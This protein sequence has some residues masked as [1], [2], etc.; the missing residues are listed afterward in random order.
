[1]DKMTVD[2]RVVECCKHLKAAYDVLK[3]ITT[4]EAEQYHKDACT[5]LE[6]IVLPSIQNLLDGFEALQKRART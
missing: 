6:C 5:A 1:M 4:I 3:P 2:E